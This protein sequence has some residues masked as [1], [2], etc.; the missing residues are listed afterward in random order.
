MKWLEITR[1]TQEGEGQVILVPW[2][3]ALRHIPRTDETCSTDHFPRVATG[4]CACLEWDLEADI[5]PDLSGVK[6]ELTS[7]PELPAWYRD[8]GPI[9]LGLHGVMFVGPARG[10]W[11]GPVS[12]E[13]PLIPENP[14]GEG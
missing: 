13:A 7:D 10:N 5:R 6:A 11:D 2:P 9:V 14:E 8:D 12:T 1:Q 4:I 3:E